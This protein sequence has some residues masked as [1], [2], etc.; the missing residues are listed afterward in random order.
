[1]ALSEEKTLFAGANSDDSSFIELYDY[2]FP[3]IY[4]YVHYRV[5]DFH[6]AEDL[7]S[8]VFEKIFTRFE[9]YRPEK[10]PLSAW[11]FSIAR[12]TITD[13]YRRRG[14]IHF[15]SLDTSAEVT[16]ADP[17]PG[18]VVCFNE[19]QQHLIKALSSLKQREREVIALK[20]W[21]G[22]SN[23]DIANL[24]GISE[25]NTGVIIFRAMRHLR[26]ILESQGVSINA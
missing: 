14:L 26:T 7:V 5:A 20:F 13:Y 22:L 6:A 10:A 21:S 23:S 18:D 1:M 24:V 4:N 17:D 15:D 16:T 3:K 11:I 9:S 8:L 19:V 25:S 2:Y 12:N